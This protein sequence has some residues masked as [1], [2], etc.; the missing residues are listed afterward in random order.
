MIIS[1]E[2]IESYIPQREPFIMID[3][4]VEATPETF[5]TDFRILADNIFIEKGILRE[6]ALIEN[7][8]Q[9]SYGWQ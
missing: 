5:K 3:N 1:K 2:K 9:S 8:A 4:L 7:I 6:F